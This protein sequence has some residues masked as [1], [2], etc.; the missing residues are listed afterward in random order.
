MK[1]KY[2]RCSIVPALMF[3]MTVPAVSQE[4]D[5]SDY[6]PVEASKYCGDN[7]SSYREFF[8]KDLYQ[9]AHGPWLNVFEDCPGSSERA[10]VDGATMFHSFIDSA[11]AGPAR[12][13]LID[14]LM[15]IYDRRMEYFGGEGNVLGRKGTDL[16]TYR[17]GDIAQVQ[18][19]YNMLKRSIELE[20][21]ESREAVLVLCL[22]AG[23]SLE[24]EGIIDINQLIE[25]YVTVIGI[26][27]EPKVRGPRWERARAAIQKSMVEAG[28]PVCTTLDT[29]FGPQFEQNR[30]DTV[31]L[32][33][34]IFTI[35]TS[36]CDSS[37]TYLTALED[38]Y[39]I[40]P[41][42]EAAH[43]LAILYIEKNDLEKA[44]DYLDK[45]TLDENTGT[46][47]RAEWYYELAVVRLA[48]RDYCAAIDAAREA[49]KLK[50]NSGKAYILLGDAFI[51]SREN[52]GD[53][54]RQRTAF[55][56]AADQYQKAGS[57]DPSVAEESTQKL[58]EI[59]LQYPGSEDVFFNDMKDGDRYLVGGC[60]NEY[61][62][63]RSGNL[64]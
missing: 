51:A 9:Y 32:H 14:T 40:E 47:T 50:N 36:G 42:P 18:D 56:A 59:A 28:V 45:A 54:F 53:D 23:A 27:G 62:T 34:V 6:N 55:W 39:S 57:V 30:N 61:T 58:D 19:A 24:K 20:G 22:S 15:L 17:G 52:L 38:L 2:F 3:M 33:R 1:G 21:K 41:R 43:D 35:R 37:E 7:I 5:S 60:I 13:A 26:L 49:I 46:E 11:A 31:F 12:E 63:V 29:Y 25:D 48:I 16:L 4:T 44:E 64:P 10:Y 8:K